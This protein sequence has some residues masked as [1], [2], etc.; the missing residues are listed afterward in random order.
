MMKIALL[1]YGKMGKMVEEIA[2]QRNHEIVS[3]N[4]DVYIDFSHPEAVLK[5]I[6]K[7]AE[8]NTNIVVGTTG[9]YD[10]LDQAQKIAENI[11]LLYSPNFSI[12]V[13]LF[14]Q[15]V[16]EASQWM[17]D[18]SQY[19]VGLYE[20]HH[21]K[22]VDSPSG[23]AKLIAET[24]TKKMKR[25]SPLEI[26][27]LRC[28]FIP[29]EHSVIFD[30]EVDQI[31]LSHKALNRKGFALGAVLAAEWLHGKKGFFTLDDFIGSHEKV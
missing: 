16:K 27:S 15:I 19:D 8:K 2:L 9:W 3:K 31:Q 17:S 24:I 10:Q 29:G 22:K 12:G 1:G 7:A 28:G 23:T 25:K 5:N 21:N 4:A 30:S 14:L 20:A 13:Y 26:S 11:G 18:F 6:E